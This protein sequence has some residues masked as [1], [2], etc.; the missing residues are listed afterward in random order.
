MLFSAAARARLVAAW[1]FAVEIALQIVAVKLFAQ[2]F[3]HFLHLLM[4]MGINLLIA[5]A[6]EIRSGLGSFRI[7]FTVPRAAAVAQTLPFA[8]PAFVRQSRLHP[9]EALVVRMSQHV[10]DG[11]AGYIADGPLLVDE[12]VAGESIAVLLKHKACRTCRPMDAQLRFAVNVNAQHVIEEAHGNLRVAVI[13]PLVEHFAEEV[14]VFLRRNFVDTGLVHLLGTEIH[15]GDELD[16][17][18]AVF[19][20]KHHQ[21]LGFAY[22]SFM[23]HRQNIEIDLVLPQM[24]D[25]GHHPVEAAFAVGSHPAG[26]MNLLGAV[27]AH[28]DQKI[29]GF[30]K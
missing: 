8:R 24:F 4:G 3:A 13:V 28:A 14:T 2:L 19:P 5:L 9:V 7:P 27:K 25:A 15:T 1:S 26:V 17:V 16:I 11:G 6:E 29:I 21:F 18:E 12:E 10:G 23:D 30:K 22:V 20:V